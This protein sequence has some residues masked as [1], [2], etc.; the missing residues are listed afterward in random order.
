MLT[1]PIT[2]SVNGKRISCRS[3]FTLEPISNFC[4]ILGYW[5]S[6]NASGDYNVIRDFVSLTKPM[7]LL[8][9]GKRILCWSKFAL[10]LIAD[11]CP[12]LTFKEWVTWP[13]CKR[14]ICFCR[15]IYGIWYPWED[16]FKK[17]IFAKITYGWIS[18]PRPLIERCLTSYFQNIQKLF[19]I[20]III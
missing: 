17:I 19:Q 3:M 1:K 14:R 6:K 10:E 16:N 12:L 18:T 20:L 7:V 2:F 8:T 11:F 15:K 13:W 9:F 4:L 5:S